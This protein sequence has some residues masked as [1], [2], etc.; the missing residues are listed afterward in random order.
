M[1]LNDIQ[2]NPVLLT[3]MY[4]DSIVEINDVPKQAVDSI[5][6]RVV[7]KKNDPGKATDTTAPEYLGNFRRK[8]LL[9]VRYPA[10][11]FLPDE[12]LNFL[13]SILGACQ[14]GI[15]DVAILNLSH[16]AWISYKDIQNNFRSSVTILFGLTPGEFEMPVNFPEFQIQPFDNCIFL[17][18]PVLEKLESDKVLKSKLWFCLKRIFNLP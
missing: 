12:Q 3:E 6:D 4:K 11:T 14:M 2:L 17:C 16:S 15:A 10:T 9:I 13:T 1:A 18:A 7:A 5:K 8:I